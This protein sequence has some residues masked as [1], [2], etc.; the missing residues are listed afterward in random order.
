MLIWWNSETCI[1]GSFLKP[2]F[3]QLLKYI[4]EEQVKRTKGFVLQV[5]QGVS[6]E[7]SHMQVAEE[8]QSAW[9][10]LPRI[11]VFAF[12]GGRHVAGGST[13]AKEHMETAL[14]K[15]EEQWTKEIK[16]E[17][18]MC[19]ERFEP[20]D[21]A[22]KVPTDS[23][24]DVHGRAKVTYP[25]GNV[26]VGEYQHGKKHGQGT[27]NYASGMVYVGEFQHGVRHGQ[28]T[29]NYASG[30]VYI[31]EYQ[32]DKR[33]GRGKLTNAE[34]AVYIGE[35]QHG[36]KHGQGKFTN[37]EGDFELGFYVAGEP[38]GEAVWF[39]KDRQKAVLMKDGEI[40]HE[41]SRS[42]AAK[43]VEELGLSKLL[44]WNV[45][46]PIWKDFGRRRVTKSCQIVVKL[47]K[48]WAKSCILFWLQ[49]Q[50]Q[51]GL[52]IIVLSCSVCHVS[53]FKTRHPRHKMKW[54]E[55]ASRLRAILVLIPFL[56]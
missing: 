23:R 3:S 24:G 33:H 11:A 8:Q 32:R 43:K 21:G 45:L 2:L 6:H 53:L 34:G 27:C 36:K 44:S 14:A 22:D 46:D 29:F 31:G 54:N 51:L 52:K 39:S 48:K 25:S 38:S 7:K 18:Q 55:M 13:L 37:A 4:C 28:G 15:A 35:Y 56:P 20:V 19:S 12:A 49:N 40:A 16:A 10:N 47:S 41:L 30:E 5:Q 1:W 26:Y 17:A 42:E 50:L 9:L